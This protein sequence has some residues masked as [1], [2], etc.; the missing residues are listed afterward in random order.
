VAHNRAASPIDEALTPLQAPFGP[1]SWRAMRPFCKPGMINTA[2][3]DDDG[4]A[5]NATPIA[6]ARCL[7]REHLPAARADLDSSKRCSIARSTYRAP[8]S[9]S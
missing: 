5:M 4:G 9:K 7:A 6:S 3:R 1:A 8:E 2:P